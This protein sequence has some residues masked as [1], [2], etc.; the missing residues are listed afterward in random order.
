MCMIYGTYICVVSIICILDYDL[1]CGMCNSSNC[2]KIYSN[3]LL[4]MCYV[5]LPVVLSIV[6]G[7]L[8]LVRID[9]DVV[10]REILVW[11]HGSRDGWSLNQC[12]LLLETHSSSRRSVDIIFVYWFQRDSGAGR[13]K[14][15]WLKSTPVQNSGSYY[16]MMNCWEDDLRIIDLSCKS[17]FVI[18]GCDPACSICI[19]LDCNMNC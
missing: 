11:E 19:F 5:M 16:Q 13:R 17:C 4:V 7:I 3:C 12:R 18:L 6:Y 1:A 15:R 14:S 8:L 10:S 9:Q 2:Y